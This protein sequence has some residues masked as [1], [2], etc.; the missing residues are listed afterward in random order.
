MSLGVTPLV[1]PDEVSAIVGDVWTSLVGSGEHLSPV[2][3]PPAHLPLDALSAWVLVVGPWTGSLVLTCA[4]ATA[5]ALARAVLRAEDDEQLTEEDVVDALGE[6]AN[7]VGGNVKALLAGPSSL[8]LPRVGHGME[9][10][11]GQLVLQLDLA[12]RG[13]PV[14]LS[15]RG[16]TTTPSKELS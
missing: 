11:T 12:W 2:A 9:A 8:G 15:L 4:P 13:Q 3:H 16:T 7:V 10:P 14:L 5:A 6:V 1:G